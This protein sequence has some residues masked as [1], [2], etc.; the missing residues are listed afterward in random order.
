MKP[1][2]TV[3]IFRQLLGGRFCIEGRAKLVKPSDWSEDHWVVK[4]IDEGFSK[5]QVTRF[6]DQNGQYNPHEHVREMNRIA[7]FAE[8]AR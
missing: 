8:E 3:T 2:D 6:V 5:R 1:G 4:F 7:G